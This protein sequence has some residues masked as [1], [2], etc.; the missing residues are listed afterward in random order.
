MA[1]KVI[2]VNEKPDSKQDKEIS[3][4]SGIQSNLSHKPI[5]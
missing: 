4:F 5:S 1:I 2:V 3:P